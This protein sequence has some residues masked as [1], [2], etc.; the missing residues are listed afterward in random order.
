MTMTRH[1]SKSRDRVELEE[2][3]DALTRTAK[4]I[5]RDIQS[6]RYGRAAAS[7]VRLW[8]ERLKFAPEIGEDIGHQAVVDHLTALASASAHLAVV[9]AAVQR[10]AAE[11]LPKHVPDA[12]FGTDDTLQAELAR[13]TETLL[14]EDR[15]REEVLPATLAP[16]ARAAMEARKRLCEREGVRR[17]RH[18]QLADALRR[19][20]GAGGAP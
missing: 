19:L 12:A 16:D 20:A 3:R 5:A 4:E 14:A 15:R 13:L 18:A 6:D 9:D 1:P 10:L 11:E 7:A 8:G 2:R 17:T